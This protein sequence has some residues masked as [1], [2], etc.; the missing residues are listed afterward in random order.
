MARYEIQVVNGQPI[1]WDTEL[2]I[3]VGNVDTCR[4]LQSA[5]VGRVKKRQRP[6]ITG[7]SRFVN[8]SGSENATMKSNLIFLGT[9]ALGAYAGMKFLRVTSD[10]ALNTVIGVGLGLVAG[11]L[12]N[13]YTK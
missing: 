1:C 5:G 13:K 8:F 10:Q 7:F 12:I 11:T 6:A 3:G 2:N 4:R 9:S